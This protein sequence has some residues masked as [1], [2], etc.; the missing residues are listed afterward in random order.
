M[1]RKRLIMQAA[2]NLFQNLHFDSHAFLNGEP[3]VVV[4][5]YL[6]AYNYSYGE[7]YRLV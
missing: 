5:Q 4:Q 2:Y 7:F 3:W 1:H 6:K